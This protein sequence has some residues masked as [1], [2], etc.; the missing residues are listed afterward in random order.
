M[1]ASA[2]TRRWP[3]A[4][5]LVCGSACAA[6]VAPATPASTPTTPA[7]VATKAPAADTPPPA[8]PD[9]VEHPADPSLTN[10]VLRSFRATTQVVPARWGQA[11]WSPDG[12]VVLDGHGAPADPYPL[13]VLESTGDADR[14][15]VYTDHVVFLVWIARDDLRP[16]VAQ[17][18]HVTKSARAPD[19]AIERRSGFTIGPGTVPDVLERRDGWARI[20][21]RDG[22]RVRGWIAEAALADR[23]VPGAIPIGEDEAPHTWWQV[24]RATQLRAKPDGQVL[25]RV[26]PEA[27]VLE[28]AKPDDAHRLVAYRV[29]C[30]EDR[31]VRGVIPRAHLRVAPISG[32]MYG[33]GHPGWTIAPAPDA[34]TAPRRPIAGNR[35]LTTPD[36]R[37]VA[38]LLHDAD[39]IDE[40]QDRIRVA[41]PWGPLV[42]QLAPDGW[43]PD[44]FVSDRE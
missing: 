13:A 1:P 18:V 30:Q 34:E 33:C 12:P 17:P 27:M 41:T 42:L 40:G 32:P 21:V 5:A 6:P 23:Y 44:G 10:A 16:V 25:A 4:W 39:M 29:R 35:W 11:R 36:G 24:R 15:R 26:E 37:P 28:I 22:V 20:D 7:P 8:E 31:I 43:A 38:M 2:L 14:V 19:R 9:E 3:I